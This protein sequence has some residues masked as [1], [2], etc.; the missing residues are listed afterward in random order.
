MHF[1]ILHV[2]T[3]LGLGGDAKNLVT[4][5]AQQRAWCEPAVATL[6][7][8]A[9]PRAIGLSKLGI[10]VWSGM[11]SPTDFRELVTAR[12]FDA[13]IIHRNGQASEPET[14]ILRELASR[15]VRLF[16]Y[17]TFAR[18]DTTT[19]ALWTGHF[20]LSRA[21]LVQYARRRRVEPE[22][23]PKHTSAGYAVELGEPITAEERRSAR[24]ALGIDR[25][26]FAIARIG[27][28]DLRKWSALPALAAARARR[29]GVPVHLLVQAAPPERQGWLRKVCRSAVSLIPPS[30]NPDDVRRTL[31]ASDC[32]ANYS[33]IGETFGLALAEAMA[34][35]LP[36]LVNSTPEADN[37]QVELCTHGCTGLVA[38]SV[39]ALAGAIGLLAGNLDFAAALGEEG[40][41]T[42][43]RLFE[44]A[45]VE[46]RVRRFMKSRM[47]ASGAAQARRVPE[48]PEP[49]Q[50][51]VDGKWV[52]E[53]AVREHTSLAATSREVVDWDA[54]TSAY[55][56][57]GD[58]LT[59][60]RK[61][62]IKASATVL[63]RR[64]RAG[65]LRRG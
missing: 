40:R 32:F 30:V 45:A 21:S 31:A 65:S 63:T 53:F 1:R 11:S 24:A 64:I 42:I 47:L 29:D 6:D 14:R 37:A 54:V 17:N 60:A 26:A 10:E 4:L 8:D 7:R 62:G 38:N 13:A 18:V 55:H 33:N 20:H 3:S 50:Y 36:T 19:D 23:L 56:R 44:P 43:Q 35:G 27:R 28:P 22:A 51:E 39:A 52:S 46:A 16:E 58:A 61:Q 57:A 2:A 34:L 12:P 41:R 5:A 15:G 48:A 59:Y 25:G 9:G 49:P